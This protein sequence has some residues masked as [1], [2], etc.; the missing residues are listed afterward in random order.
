MQRGI[1]PVPEVILGFSSD[2]VFLLPV[3]CIGARRT[4]GP[5][6]GR[7]V[8]VVVVVVVVI[9]DVVIVVI[10]VIV[11]CVA[12]QE[13]RGEALRRSSSCRCDH[14]VTIRRGLPQIIVKS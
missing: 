1:L 11:E 14:R 3:P 10:V 6:R 5:G 13:V 12:P 7:V 9:V 2:A 4:P 8:V